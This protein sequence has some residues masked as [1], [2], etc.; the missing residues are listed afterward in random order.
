[1]RYIRN[2]PTKGISGR[3]AFA[4]VTGITIWGIWRYNNYYADFV[5]VQHNTP[6]LQ[7]QHPLLMLCSV[8]SA[9]L[10]LARVQHAA[11]VVCIALSP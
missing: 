7:I 11:G 8:C 10:S 6:T 1:M 9:A 3:A 5:Y 2:L 4:L